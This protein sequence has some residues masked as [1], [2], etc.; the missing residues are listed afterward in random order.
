M[1]GRAP[2]LYG[3]L[4]SLAFGPIALR[5]S[6]RAPATGSI[7]GVV[8]DSLLSKAGLSGAEVSVDG[9]ELTALTDH[10]GRFRL[11]GVPAGR[12][13]VRFYHPRLDS[14]GFG[15]APVA[16]EVTDAKTASVTLTTPSSATLYSRVCRLKRAP[17][18][19][20][21]LGVV[22]NVDGRAPLPNAEVEVGWTEW[23]V[24]KRGL[25]RQDRRETAP[26]NAQGAYALC[27]VPTDVS[28][29]V[30][31]IASSHITGFAEIN[32]G[33]E[34]FD[35][36][37]F[38]VS[39]A[40]SDA[41]TA[42]LAPLD[43]AISRGDSIAPVGSASVRGVIRAPDGAP[44]ADAQVALMG[45]P[46]SVRSSTDGVFLLPR[47]PAGSQTIEVRAIG[48]SR[49]RRALELTTG[50]RRTLDMTLDRVVE[51][52]VAN[53]VGKGVRLDRTGFEERRAAGVG[54]FIGPE[55]V[56]RRGAFDAQQLLYG[57]PGSRIIWDG[58]KNVV[59]FTRPFGVGT[60]FVGFDNLCL[61]YVFVDGVQAPDLDVI[62]GYQVRAMEIYRNPATAPAPY[63][64]T[65][66]GGQSC[67]ILLV[68]TKAPAPKRKR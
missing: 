67:A 33:Q 19:G 63:R 10:T 11:D 34:I 1:T 40:D 46:V 39:L 62:R 60:G 31:A 16:V 53:I 30:R 32:F 6:P 13:A 68:W 36:T 44:M 57:V 45:F 23:T 5:L 35:V 64:L 20:M 50:E 51:L 12:V 24:G 38:A 7:T 65:I 26:T 3:I 43:S 59:M 48:Y 29:A 18:S 61:P 21:L 4:A 56:E 15:V 28:V 27:G 52:P 14:L 58:S 55:E 17:S 25:V 66:T 2:L 9:T 54:R 41:T 47:V 8:Y 22:R 42:R 49:N 37:D